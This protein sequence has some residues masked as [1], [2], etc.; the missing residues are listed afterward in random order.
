[1]AD[2]RIVK[3]RDLAFIIP[4]TEKGKKYLER[5]FLMPVTGE[6]TVPLEVLDE[7]IEKFKRS[8]SNLEIAE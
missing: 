7:V 2:L 6:F 5:H 8:K 1:M 4:D 3:Q